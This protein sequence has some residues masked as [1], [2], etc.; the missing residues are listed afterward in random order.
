MQILYNYIMSHEI[1]PAW[2]YGHTREIV[3]CTFSCLGR[4][5]INLAN[6]KFTLQEKLL[7][8][9]YG[10]T[11]SKGGDLESETEFIVNHNQCEEWILKEGD[12]DI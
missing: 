8:L 7:S 3:Y 10:S 9:K 5:I 1:Y 4:I 11:H 2:L 12:R 6:Y